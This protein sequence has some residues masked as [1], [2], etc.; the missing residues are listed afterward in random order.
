MATD[1]TQ[2]VG[3][4]YD[5]FLGLYHQSKQ[6]PGTDAPDAKASGAFIAFASIGTP[7]TP[8]MFKLQS[9]DFDKGLVTQQFTLR[10]NQIPVLDGASVA[11]PGLLTVDGAYGMMLDGALR[12]ERRRHSR[13]PRQI[14]LSPA[15]AGSSTRRCRT[16]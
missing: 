2:L 12:R 1:L 13:M 9:G 6:K 7:M 16:R 10:A 15:W 14:F 8:E 5:Y 4:V 3:E 11:A